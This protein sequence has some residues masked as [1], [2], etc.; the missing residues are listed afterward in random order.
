MPISDPSDLVAEFKK[1]GEFDKLRRELLANSQLSNGFEAFKA[2]VE[3]IARERLGSGQ[4]AYTAPEHVHKELMQEINRFPIV[5]RFASEAPMLSDSAFKDGIRASLQRIL[6]EDRGQ[7]DPPASAEPP[8]QPSVPPP[9]DSVPS[10]KEGEGASAPAPPVLPLQ[11][12]SVVPP[13]PPGTAPEAQLAGKETDVDT[14]NL[15]PLT[16][17]P[18]TVMSSPKSSPL[19]SPPGPS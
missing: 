5:E 2:R 15:A 6:R 4:M 3:E 10:V 14:I 9:I 19:S 18:E 17:A 16:D 12:P 11:E 1:S 8:S 7:K 13:V